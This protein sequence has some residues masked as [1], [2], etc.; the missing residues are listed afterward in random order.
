MIFLRQ[1]L[2]PG[3]DSRIWTRLCLQMALFACVAGGWAVRGAEVDLTKLPPAASAPVDFTR[4]IRPIFESTCFRCHG[5]EKPKSKF[6]LDNRE[7]ALKGGENGVDIVPGRSAE[8]SLIHYVARL[9]SDM[10]MPPEGKGDPLTPSKISLLRGWIDQGAT[11]PE[12]AGGETNKMLF[13]VSTALQWVT[14]SGN[15][16]KFREHWWTREG[17]SGGVQELRV[18][19]RLGEGRTLLLE[20][21]ALGNQED[22]QVKL[23]LRQTDLGFLQGGFERYNK[24]YSDAGGYSPS[25]AGSPF[26]SGQ[27]LT[28]ETGRAWVEAGLTL[29]D[30]PRVV[31]GYEYQFTDGIKSTLQWGDSGTIDPEGFAPTDAKKIYPARKG[32]DE[33][34]HIIK[35][36]VNHEARG[37]TFQDNFRAEFYDLKTSRDDTLF[38]NSG[39]GTSEKYALVQEAHDHFQAANAIRLEKQVRDWLLLSG[40]YLYSHLDGEAAFNQTTV[41]PVNSFTA[42]DQFWFSNALLLDQESHVFNANASLGPWQGLSLSA[43]V[44]SEWMKQTGFG[45]MRLDQ[46]LPGPT[47]VAAPAMLHS[48]LDKAAVEEQLDLRYTS[49][50]YTILF[51]NARLQQESIGQ[52]EQDVGGA[53]E[54]LRDTD[55]SMRGFD[56]R[57]GFNVS[58]WSKV[59]LT[60]HYRVRTRHSAYNHLTDEAFGAPNDGYSAFIRGRDINTDEVMAKLSVRPAT[61]MKTSFTF[62]QVAMDYLTV[63]A[64]YIFPEIPDVP[65]IPAVNYSPGGEIFSGNYDA[66]VYSLNATL[67]PWRRIYLANTVVFRDSRTETAA[68]GVAS[69]APYRGDTWSVLSSATIVLDQKTDLR[70]SYDYSRSDYRQ[71]TDPAGLP[72]GIRY[73]L[74]GVTAGITRQIRTNVSAALQYRFYAYDEPSS[75]GQNDYTAHGIF[76]LMSI[77]L[78]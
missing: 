33:Q 8:S 14:V 17:W 22:Y 21:R 24:Y 67:T 7:A 27:D 58:P 57:F 72:L 28:L 30:R 77:S 52:Y 73:D 15:E 18:E 46:G 50:P 47:L 16:S 5:P 2:G 61:W 69:V 74:H 4:D 56:S 54:F 20:S 32:I 75:A 43:G 44:Q 76:A 53:S 55:A 71:Y 13:S 40:G 64:P 10:E 31:L 70:L 65:P 29:P 34:V 49:I 6:R 41:S 1:A 62:Q 68:N 42:A 45:D 19:E 38:Y 9:V 12:G 60:A 35:L 23:S 48:D 37:Y 26:S 59:S 51:A 66:H 36:D 63:T 3:R 39:T 11:Y 78:H 25:V